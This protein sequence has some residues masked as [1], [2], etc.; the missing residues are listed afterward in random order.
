MSLAVFVNTSDGFADCWAPF[1]TLFARYAP[2]LS[3]L[4]I[5]LN[6]ERTQF[7]C[8]PLDIRSTRVWPLDEL[9]RPTWSQC[10]Q[11]G[12]EAVAEPYILFLLEDYFLDTPVREDVVFAALDA[13][14]STEADVVYLNAQGPRYTKH[15]PLTGSFLDIIPPARYLVN[16]Q[17]AIWD[18]QFL[19]SLIREWENAWMFEIFASMRARSLRGKFAAVA[20]EILTQSPVFEHIHTGVARGK[21]QVECV[22]LFER[23]GI[24]MDFTRRGFY[25]RGSRMQ[26]RLE[27]LAKL[28][29]KPV[30]FLQSLLSVVRS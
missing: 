3:K 20:P 25:Q 26:F 9:V 5:Y 4:P 19:L 23:E 14:Q 2:Q 11:R 28:I 12:L 1:F 29:D 30:P 17:A 16:T 7:D 27:V 15:R 6:T 24:S 10:L 13:V 22:P 18:R 21:W 8:P